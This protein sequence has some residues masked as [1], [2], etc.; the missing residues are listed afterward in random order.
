MKTI[1]D[2]VESQ[3]HGRSRRRAV[4]FVDARPISRCR[5]GGLN[6]RWPDDRWTQDHRLQNY[7]GYAA[8]AFARANNIDRII[9]NP[10]RAQ[11]GIVASGKAY[12]ETREALVLARHR[13]RG[14]RSA[15]GLRLYKIGMPWPLEPLRR[16]RI[17]RKGCK[18]FSSSKSGARWSR[19]RSSR[20]LFNCFRPAAA[21][22]RQVRRERQTVLPAGRRNLR[23]RASPM[24]WSRGWSGSICRTTICAHLVDAMPRRSGAATQAA[25][26]IHAADLAH[27][28]ITA[29]AVRITPRPRCRKAAAPSPASAATTWR[30][31]WTATPRPSPRWAAKARTWVG[32]APFTDEKHIFAN[33][34]DGTYFHSGILAIRQAVAAGANITYKIL[35]NDAVAMTGG[36]AVDGQLTV[37]QLIAS[38]RR[39][40]RRANLSP[41]GA[42]PSAIAKRPC[43]RASS[44]SIAT[45]STACRR[46]CA[47]SPAAP[48]SSTIRPA[49]PN[50]A[51]SAR[52]A[53]VPQAAERAY[54]NPRGL[55]RLRRLLGRRAIASPSIRSKPNSVASA[56]STNRPAI[57]IS[58]ASRASARLSSRS[59]AAR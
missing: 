35:F 7:K 20:H 40:R 39:R 47:R 45:R 41:D 37:P 8:L 56:R 48:P 16:A 15:I 25:R 13:R 6:F 1:A 54:I 23:P 4:E 51:A 44:S 38:D 49:P 53:C 43:R 12:E 10:A 42:S 26:Q 21:H 55:R 33:L 9:I 18:R 19:T 50:C 24:C 3:R 32:I 46:A 58:P 34:G 27:C 30:T 5:D 29:P 52:A 57:S 14:W 22:R 31:G 17:Q 59:A 36:Q 2:T 28:R 11:F